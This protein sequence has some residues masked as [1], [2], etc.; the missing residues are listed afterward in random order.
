MSN[1]HLA[2]EYTNEAINLRYLE[3]LNACL[4][5]NGLDPTVE[6]NVWLLTKE[7]R[8]ELHE[9]NRRDFCVQVALRNDDKKTLER[10]LNV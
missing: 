7:E 6:S 8:Q 9:Q 3:R 1:L 10:L 5:D 4:E 2:K